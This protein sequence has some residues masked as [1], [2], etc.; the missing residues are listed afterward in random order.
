MHTL[1]F[2]FLTFS[3]FFPPSKKKKGYIEGILALSVPGNGTQ[4]PKELPHI[5]LTKKLTE[6]HIMS[7]DVSAQAQKNL[8]KLKPTSEHL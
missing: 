3:L 6:N 8:Q 2:F 7:L 4:K 1:F 5:S